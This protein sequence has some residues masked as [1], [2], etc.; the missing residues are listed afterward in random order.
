MWKTLSLWRENPRD[1]LRINFTIIKS[2]TIILMYVSITILLLSN[3]FC[4]F[5]VFSKAAILCS[6]LLGYLL[7]G[8]N[9]LLS[10]SWLSSWRRQ[11][12]ALSSFLH[13]SQVKKKNLYI[14][15]YIYFFFFSSLDFTL[16]FHSPHKENL[17]AKAIKFFVALSINK[18]IFLFSLE[19][20]I[21][22]LFNKE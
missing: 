10:P 16:Y 9:S 5:C 4:F 15:I 11:L 1:K 18:T 17:W 19:L 21:H 13:S 12:F 3:Q 14:Y 2:I 22:Y 6:L 8:G 20:G 7:E